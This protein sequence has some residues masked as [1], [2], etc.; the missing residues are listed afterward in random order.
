MKRFI[1]ILFLSL[2]ALSPAGAIRQGPWTKEQAWEWYERQPWMRGCNY[3]SADCANRVDQWQKLG[4]EERF[5][6]QEEEL[7]LAESIGFNTMRIIIAE[8][9]FGVWYAD[10]KGFMERFDRTL[11]LLDRH[12]MRAIVVLGNDCSRPRQLWKLPKPGKQHYDWGYHGGRKLSQ[13]GSFPGAIGY[14]CLD[15]PKLAPKFYEM[16]RE[17]ITAHRD[18]ARIAVWNLWNEPGNN[19]RKS[20]T[21]VNLPKLFEI[22]W[23]IDPVQPLAADVWNAFDQESVAGN[24]SDIISYHLYSPLED[25]I[26]VSSILME[27]YGRPMINTEWLARIRHCNVQDIYPWFEQ[28]RI[29]CTMW[30]FVAGKYQTYEPWEGMWASIDR[31]EDNGYEM[32]KWFHDLYRPSHRPYDPEEIKIITNI[33]SEADREFGSAEGRTLRSA[34]QSCPDV[35]I[36]SQDMWNGYR[37][38]RFEY[39]GCLAWIVE[40]GVAPAQGAPWTW[41]MAQ[42]DSFVERTGVTDLLYKGWRHVAIEKYEGCPVKAFAALHSLLV[43]ELGFGPKAAVIGLGQGGAAAV[44]YAAAFPDSVSSLY[45]DGPL[46]KC[47][48]GET[49][50]SAFAEKI[51]TIPVLLYYGSE[52]AYAVPSENAEPFI[53]ALTAAGGDLT[54]C[55]REFYGHFP[56]GEESGR[57]SAITDFLMK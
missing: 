18:D 5:K 10:R 29:G 44:E 32:T 8:E 43:A 13:H 3:M 47:C 28:N 27:K 1:L 17:I 25:Q 56:Y 42:P 39:D 21:D 26:R 12:H 57:I 14:T 37:R 20:L 15:D 50:L 35:K 36:L 53:E 9:G 11:D 49:G 34:M 45:L 6:Q 2:M 16:C 24:L 55:K 30:G 33:N 4:F 51:S 22:A 48:D 52:D 40:P 46:F 38:I 54:V 7:A 19:A 23:E 31:G 41:S